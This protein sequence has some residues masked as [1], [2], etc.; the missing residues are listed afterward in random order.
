MPCNRPLGS[1]S[2]S[3]CSDCPPNLSHLACQFLL[4]SVFLYCWLRGG[5]G[6]LAVSGVSA[7]GVHLVSGLAGLGE[8]F[9]IK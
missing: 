1:E 7:A 5:A 6:G 8:H 2:V 9:E 4:L 3:V